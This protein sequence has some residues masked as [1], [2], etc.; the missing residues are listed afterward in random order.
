MHLASVG[1][2]DERAQGRV[3]A[4]VFIDVFVVFRAITGRQELADRTLVVLHDWVQQERGDAQVRQ[5][6]ELGDHALQVASPI[7][8][9]VAVAFLEKPV[10]HEV[11]RGVAIEEFLDDDD[12]DDLVLPATCVAAGQRQG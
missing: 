9:L 3:V 1:R 5:V 6:I 12:V 11:I 7:A 10:A 2:V 4:K 8:T